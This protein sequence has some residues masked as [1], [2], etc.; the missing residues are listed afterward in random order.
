MGEGIGGRKRRRTEVGVAAGRQDLHDASADLKDAHVKGSA[1][2]VEN[3]GTGA[4]QVAA[5]ANLLM[6]CGIRQEQVI[7]GALEH[8]RTGREGR[9]G[10][11]P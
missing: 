7:G 1:A 9:G 5:L 4:G 11:S 3:L 2:E 6:P 10:R 8:G